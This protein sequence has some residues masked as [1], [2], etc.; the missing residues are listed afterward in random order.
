[1]QVTVLQKYEEMVKEQ[2]KPLIDLA[3]LLEINRKKEIETEVKKEMGIDLAEKE[4]EKINKQANEIQEKIFSLT[5][6]TK[7]YGISIND[8]NH[9]KNSPFQKEIERRLNAENNLLNKIRAKAKE[10]IDHIWLVQMPE[11]TVELL[12]ELKNNTIPEFERDLL[13]Q[14]KIVLQ[15]PK[16]AKVKKLKI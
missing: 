16:S 3:S 14:K 2:F 5:G 10:M 11:K 15:E 7:S 6:D 1:M 8:S 13:K 9:P 12:E 4:L